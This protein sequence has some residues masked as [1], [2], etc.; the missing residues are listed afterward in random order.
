MKRFIYKIL[1]KKWQK[2]IIF[3]KKIT[4]ITITLQSN[5]TYWLLTKKI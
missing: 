4:N 5:R 3:D 1:E 2:N